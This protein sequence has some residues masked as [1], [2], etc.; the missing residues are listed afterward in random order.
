MP[1]DSQFQPN[2]GT[3]LATFA[4]NGTYS[5]AIQLNGRLVGLY[6]EPAD[7]ARGAAGSITFRSSW[8]PAGTGYPV[9]TNDGTVLRVLA[10]ATGQFYTFGEPRWPT[11]GLEYL[12]LQMGTDG[13]ATAASGGT[14]V[15]ITEN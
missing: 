8:N 4:Q 10:F 14:I 2:F 12:R 5:G 11:A 9:Q 1:S 3:A 15:L 13:T 7:F 6:A